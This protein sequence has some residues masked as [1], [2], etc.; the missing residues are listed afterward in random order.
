A[1]DLGAIAAGAVLRHPAQAEHRRDVVPAQ[2]QPDRGAALRDRAV[3][4]DLAAEATGVAPRL[5]DPRRRG[6]GAQPRRRLPA[7]GPP[8]VREHAT[9]G[10]LTPN[11]LR[12]PVCPLALPRATALASEGLWRGGAG[13]T[14]PSS[15]VVLGHVVNGLHC[16]PTHT[17]PAGL[18]PTRA[19]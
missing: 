3:A 2:R 19:T 6:G 11:P 1:A 12:C 5:A 14:D 10:E 15:Q 8:R 9:P 16:A 17:R 7:K 4:A 18:L 13:A